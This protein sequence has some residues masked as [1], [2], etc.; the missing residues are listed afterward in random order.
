VEQCIKQI[1]VELRKLDRSLNSTLLWTSPDITP[2]SLILYTQRRLDNLLLETQNLLTA[3]D[4]GS[5]AKLVSIE[6]PM[7][8]T[9]LAEQ[10]KICRNNISNILNQQMHLLESDKIRSTL[11]TVK[12]WGRGREVE[13]QGLNEDQK[14]NKFASDF[15]NSLMQPLSP[16]PSE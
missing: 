9:L 1:A 10:C 7:P 11:P 4:S 14:V 13:L 8:I 5:Y 12:E 16:E 6:N 3:C 15:I 2:L